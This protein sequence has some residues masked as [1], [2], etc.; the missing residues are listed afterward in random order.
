MHLP[1]SDFSRPDISIRASSSLDWQL[2]LDKG[3]VQETVRRHLHS[4]K[5]TIQQI[6]KLKDSRYSRFLLRISDGSAVVLR[7]GPTPSGKLLR[8]ERGALEA[9]GKVLDLLC[10]E[11]YGELPVAQC[12]NKEPG[13]ALTFSPF[14][15]TTYI[16][17]LSFR[18]R[19]P[20]LTAREK[21]DIYFELGDIV[22]RISQHKS[23]Y[24][25]PAA[26]ILSGSGSRSWREAFASMMEAILRDAEDMLVLLPYEQIRELTGRFMP[27][28]E[29]ITESRLL[30]ISVCDPSNI[31]LDSQTNKINNLAD[32]S[33]CLWGDVFM[34]D[35][36]GLGNAAF[37]RGFGVCQPTT[38]PHN[39]RRLLYACYRSL[40]SIV[41][42]YY[43]PCEGH[44][45]LEQRKVLTTVLSELAAEL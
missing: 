36:F 7:L 6:E 26:P 24:F 22:R 23:P 41:E 17:G 40:V 28:L 21:E 33:T 31:I 8:H 9:E 16:P 35:V 5:V 37:W 3:I 20:F 42:N 38:P 10:G 14:I 2:A 44:S 1:S 4:S 11:L 19:E 13:K 12:L 39:C 25:G 45:E 29:D 18:D 27:L 30:L 34:S 32:F 15:L 43:R